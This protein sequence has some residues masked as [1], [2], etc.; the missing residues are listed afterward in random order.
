MPTTRAPYTPF[1]PGTLHRT[2]AE[3][4]QTHAPEATPGIKPP[5][6]RLSGRLRR[7]PD[8][9]ILKTDLD[10]AIADDPYINDND[11]ADWLKEQDEVDAAEEK[12]RGFDYVGTGI[13]VVPGIAGSVIG[14][15]I[16]GGAGAAGG[17]VVPVAG[18]AAGAAGGA[19]LGSRVGG[20][21]GSAT[22]EALA[23][24]WE[25]AS[26][27]RK[28]PMSWGSVGVQGGLGMA[29]PGGGLGAKLAS[30]AMRALAR[31]AGEG[32]LGS[33]L[34]ATGTVATGVTERHAAE[35]D[36]GWVAALPTAE[37]ALQE[38][39]MGGAVGGALGLVGGGAGN[40]YQY[41]KG[42]PAP[43]RAIT[44]RRPPPGYV[45]DERFAPTP[46][47]ELKPW[48][49][50][51]KADPWYGGLKESLTEPPPPPPPGA[52]PP[53][54]RII[55]RDETT[56]ELVGRDV[57]S[58]PAP[59]LT[60]DELAATEA[61]AARE[62][63]R[64]A[65]GTSQE[66]SAFAELEA[67][68]GR[69]PNADI[70]A[71]Y[72]AAGRLIPT[73]RRPPIQRRAPVT[74]EPAAVAPVAPEP[75]AAVPPP[76]PVESPYSVGETVSVKRGAYREPGTVTAIMP[77]GEVIVQVGKE[78]GPNSRPIRRQ[79]A[80]EDVQPI[81]LATE[82]AP[83]VAE[84]PAEPIQTDT[85][86]M[87]KKSRGQLGTLERVL[88]SSLTPAER[89]EIGRIAA[90]L[91][92]VVYT[93]RRGVEQ[94][95][96]PGME[97]LPGSGGA[98]VLGDIS[99]V[100]DTRGALGKLKPSTN[101]RTLINSIRRAIETG[102]HPGDIWWERIVDVARKRLA[103]DTEVSKP[104][105]PP[106]AGELWNAAHTQSTA[107]GNENL[108]AVGN[109]SR[110]SPEGIAGEI[111]PRP[112]ATEIDYGRHAT[113]AR[114]TGFAGTDAQ[115]QS[116]FDEKLTQARQLQEDILAETGGTLDLPAAL[117]G[118]GVYDGA[119]WWEPA[120]GA[121]DFAPPPED[122]NSLLAGPPEGGNLFGRP[123]A[124]PT[125]I[126]P[127]AVTQPPSTLEQM[128]TPPE[129]IVPRE[130]PAPGP[131]NLATLLEPSPTA[132]IPAE[133]VPVG[134]RPVAPAKQAQG[135]SFLAPADKD[136]IF[137][138]LTRDQATPETRAALKAAGYV[139]RRKQGPEGRWFKNTIDRDGNVLM[140]PA[141]AE[142]EAAAILGRA[143]PAAEAPPPQTLETTLTPEP[144]AT[145]ADMPPAPSSPETAAAQTD[146]EALLQGEL[147]PNLQRRT[148]EQNIR[149]GERK[150]R[151]LAQ[152]REMGVTP[153]AAVTGGQPRRETP[154]PRPRTTPDLP[155]PGL[156]PQD[157]PR[158]SRREP[159]AFAQST[160]ERKLGWA[161]NHLDQYIGA[162][163]RTLRNLGDPGAQ[164]PLHETWKGIKTSRPINATLIDA[165]DTL[166]AAADAGDPQSQYYLSAWE[167]TANERFTA[168]SLKKGTRGD[169]A[170]EGDMFETSEPIENRQ[171][172]G[173]VTLYGGVAGV[174]KAVDA[175][176]DTAFGR[177]P[178]L[179]K[180]LAN[181]LTRAVFGY[182][183][184]M[185][186]DKG[187]KDDS[188]KWRLA[189]SA[190]GFLSKDIGRILSRAAASASKT[191]RTQ[192][193]KQIELR[194]PRPVVQPKLPPKDVAPTPDGLAQIFYPKEELNF[195]Q[196]LRGS[197][198][199]NLPE[200]ANEIS[201][202][203]HNFNAARSRPTFKGTPQEIAALRKQYLEPVAKRMAKTAIDIK[204]TSK[205]KASVMFAVVNALRDRPEG[206]S[207]W[208][209]EA[210]FK[211]NLQKKIS[212]TT[213]ALTY[214]T[215]IGYNPGTMVQNATQPLL[216]LSYVPM[217]FIHNGMVTA[218]TAA[219]KMRSMSVHLDRPVDLIDE[220]TYKG[221]RINNPKL[222]KAIAYWKKLPVPDAM[223][224][225][226]WG[227]NWN[228]QGVFLGAMDYAL[229]KGAAE[230]RAM[231]WA[232][233]VVFKTQGATGILGS[234][235]NWRGPV[236]GLIAPFTKFP[237]LFVEQMATLFSRPG[238][239]AGKLRI[240]ST[241]GALMV[242][243]EVVGIDTEDLLVS[244]GRPF[245]LDIGNPGKSIARLK[246]GQ[247]LPIVKGIG[248]G[249][250]ASW[251]A[252][253]GAGAGRL[254]ED[255]T[256][257][258][259]T[260]SV[261][262]AGQTA[263]EM[264]P[265]AAKG[266]LLGTHV[267][268]DPMGAAVPHTGYEDL[269]NLIGL[270]TQRQNETRQ[271]YDAFQG[272]NAPKQAL[273]ARQL[274][275]TKAAALKALDQNDL[276]GMATEMAKLNSKQRRSLL[277][278]RNRTRFQRIVQGMSKAD[279]LQVEKDWSEKFKSLELR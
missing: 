192:V 94:F 277:S 49:I 117:D 54:R 3:W 63:A 71:T 126:E 242:A 9:S 248:E 262:R 183:A 103:G 269:L 56:G 212:R 150:A 114:S 146:I 197:T 92:E 202:A 93:P 106:E 153:E 256:T 164:L 221:A 72:D 185:Q 205:R 270:R 180:N 143:E 250:A 267:G 7:Q 203:E 181:R 21:L 124:P 201:A 15:L 149:A 172:P 36:K 228:R 59:V 10:A 85:P 142:A 61:E 29:I 91:E 110:P 186:M 273:H 268:H 115:L 264:L 220:A 211:Y 53:S 77:N 213:S 119:R 218:K 12:A 166:K 152:A 121:A 144:A 148:V 18:T 177:D 90:E 8:G 147:T 278:G 249:L 47:T 13:R 157:A 271:A 139:F 237:T 128:F 2:L 37:Q 16:G 217:K 253:S 184:G 136:Y 28:G 160:P 31:T 11:V 113:A 182:V 167:Q 263:R 19:L 236:M 233:Q 101:A 17:S 163:V 156:T 258:A 125:P 97:Q 232:T 245:G 95:G 272:E 80:A 254:G 116:A 229:S 257:L 111:R 44:G 79:Y 138:E 100:F 154:L 173:G 188:H 86:I 168:K 266:N 191:A 159:D 107:L 207:K 135:G 62:A 224:M 196:W 145:A 170:T 14:G 127:P 27:R 39:K 151:T 187:D 83:V 32:V 261:T 279:R 274:Q 162:E 122:L 42:L 259:L 132:G 238:N 190:G 176:M 89:N 193:A 204:G 200:W 75:V 60:P 141:D 46:Q 239:E 120:T 216:A 64:V 222:E 43:G 35:P 24:L 129:P 240:M 52:E 130:T 118:V 78:A 22:G 247:A 206:L 48:E 189:L 84:P 276:E 81:D 74:P 55:V 112:D 38:I 252:V 123:L 66:R 198:A 73:V 251:Q 155:E 209:D 69:N 210:G 161:M 51:D 70:R 194:E 230:Q 76:P 140:T 208:L 104:F 175:A 23:Q 246:S 99:N 219:G 67:I 260:K 25:K 179:A 215:L 235:P 225:L 234:N 214:R 4:D 40:Y 223:A 195:F 58:E 131:D 158:P 82:T 165:L 134:V 227:D 244:G 98:P 243:G 65:A 108:D 30:P 1:Q 137:V 105:L 88:V 20:G 57:V 102:Q 178:N 50:A 68:L 255:L 231:E 26:G 171:T 174:D 45:P 96:E 33:A 87:G 34:G 109:A 265:Q 241:L 275:E 133:T 226:R 41:R 5:R 169:V 6:N 199:E